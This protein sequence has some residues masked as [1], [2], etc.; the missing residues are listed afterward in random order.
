MNYQ[1][2]LTALLY[3]VEVPLSV[4]AGFELGVGRYVLGA[5]ITAVLMLMSVAATITWINAQTM[6]I[7]S[8]I[9]KSRNDKRKK[10]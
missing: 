1:K 8:K 2:Y 5:I 6:E 4:W 7:N 10:R 3:A 9:N